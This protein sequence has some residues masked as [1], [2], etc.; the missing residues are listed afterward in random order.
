MKKAVKEHP[1]RISDVLRNKSISSKRAKRKR[2][3]V[4][5]IKIFRSGKVLVIT[6]QR[7]NMKRLFTAVSYNFDL[8]MTLD[9]KELFLKYQN[10]FL[11]SKNNEP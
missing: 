8:L 9:M 10:L 11:K 4:V 7:V 3:C 5:T 6:V 2:I 1:L